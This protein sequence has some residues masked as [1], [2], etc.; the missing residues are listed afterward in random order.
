MGNHLPCQGGTALA[1][2]LPKQKQKVFVP[3]EKKGFTNLKPV[4]QKCYAP[5][6]HYKEISE[7]TTNLQYLGIFQAISRTEKTKK[8]PACSDP[9]ISQSD[10]KSRYFG[11]TTCRGTDA[12]CHESSRSAQ[13]NTDAGNFLSASRKPRLHF[14]NPGGSAMFKK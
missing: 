2:T 5:V 4:S 7:I 6:R 8:D 9:S 14:H 1:S 13:A 10:G 11:P 12:C 3:S